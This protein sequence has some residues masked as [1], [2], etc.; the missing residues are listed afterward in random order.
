MAQLEPTYLRYIYDGLV[1]GSIHPDNAAELPDGLIGLYEEAFDERQPVHKRQKLLERFAVWA[2]LKK[3]VSAAFVAEIL[4]ESEDE[5]QD[6]IATYS[7]WFN[8]PESGKYQLYHERLKVYLLQRVTSSEIINLNEQ[9][10]SVLNKSKETEVIEYY[11]NF[12]FFHYWIAQIG[13]P[14][15]QRFKF[16]I[17][18][19][20][21]LD[22]QL[23]QL[24]NYSPIFIGF[25]LAIQYFSFKRNPIVYELIIK[26]NTIVVNEFDYLKV[27]LKKN[28]T[29]FNNQEH[30]Q[31]KNL[32]NRIGDNELYF[33]HLIY[34]LS[35]LILEKS[36][37][38]KIFNF[39][40][41]EIKDYLESD[42][43]PLDF[44]IPLISLVILVEF[45]Q[46][47]TD[48][49]IFLFD[50]IYELK[51]IDYNDVINKNSIWV[52]FHHESTYLEL[53]E[54]HFRRIFWFKNKV[55]SRYVS[56]KFI[57]E[58]WDKLS[59]EQKQ[60]LI[61]NITLSDVS[62]LKKG[63]VNLGL[64]AHFIDILIFLHKS[65][66]IELKEIHEIYFQLLNNKKK[67]NFDI[68]HS[69]IYFIKSFFFNNLRLKE[70]RK[71]MFLFF[72]RALRIK[73]SVLFEIIINQIDYDIKIIVESKLK[74]LI[75][76]KNDIRIKKI[77]QLSDS[78][79]SLSINRYFFDSKYVVAD[80]ASSVEEAL[81]KIA[82][83]TAWV[84]GNVYYL[85]LKNNFDEWTL[86][87]KIEQGNKSNPDLYYTLRE[88]EL[89][90]LITQFERNNQDNLIL[91]KINKVQFFPH[92][93]VLASQVLLITEGNRHKIID[94]IR[95]II[96]KT[97]ETVR[98]LFNR[99]LISLG[100]V[101]KEKDF[102][103]KI[104]I[105]DYKHG[106]EVAL[107]NSDLLP[108]QEML[109]TSSNECV[110]FI[111]SNYD[112]IFF[113]G[114]V[115]EMIFSEYFKLLNDK[116]TDQIIESLFIQSGEITDEFDC[117]LLR[118]K[119]FELDYKNS[120]SFDL[121]KWMNRIE[122]YDNPY[123]KGIAHSDIISYFLE[124]NDLHLAINYFE[125][126][127]STDSHDNYPKISAWQ[128]IVRY[129]LRI[130]NFN[131]AK[132]WF[133]ELKDFPNSEFFPSEDEF[134]LQIFISLKNISNY[135]KIK[136]FFNS[137]KN[138]LQFKNE[139][140]KFQLQSILEFICGEYDL[141]QFLDNFK[142]ILE[143][144]F[145]FDLTEIFELAIRENNRY[146]ILK[147]LKNS[148]IK[149]KDYF[150][151]LLFNK[152]QKN[153]FIDHSI[154]DWMIEMPSLTELYSIIAWS[155]FLKIKNHE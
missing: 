61:N 30:S 104:R 77:F 94:S 148:Q 25:K 82:S 9:L 21:Y 151:N 63:G 53:S 28:A 100:L 103:K 5:I 128:N 60:L 101:V 42:T 90:E 105:L 68:C 144:W 79:N 10:I 91:D 120:N 110:K 116:K 93:E 135:K 96:P 75:T 113:D 114:Q 153:D 102:L 62:I 44:Y 47:R 7:A 107:R 4:G 141:I 133:N 48:E 143:N 149:K 38:D 147:V 76:K 97:N 66:K 50:Y 27:I 78:S 92:K 22:I 45:D 111:F 71:F 131:L 2:L 106:T 11:V 6:F 115:N 64:N 87:M 58:I 35:E 86:K 155:E 146:E 84:V 55:S 142:L 118:S 74:I 12:G 18:T 108:F 52:K 69:A 51:L 122:E 88:L 132:T 24:S 129:L 137:E 20:D 138:N 124:N 26:A 54:N 8:S 72:F 85:A 56:L 39:I 29:D 3:E 59:Q 33:Q 32:S 126:Y 40:V 46:N 34:S 145:E 43:I 73:S 83:I 134:K 81:G 121:K 95:K 15:D 67:S 49:L 23:K 119:L 150:I 125:K 17:L 41:N 37:N 16:L 117:Y 139:I 31:L 130:G 136:E 57:F 13:N 98:N 70:K 19:N 65:N 89:V 99:I 109:K 154:Y 1:K 14:N 123:W 36:R 80:L 127:L 140:N 152:L 112:R